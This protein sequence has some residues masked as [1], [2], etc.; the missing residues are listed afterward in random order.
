METGPRPLIERIVGALIP[1]PYREHVLGDLCQR[2]KSDSQYV[3]DACRVVPHVLW[4]QIRRT[5]SPTLLVAEFVLVY[6]AFASAQLPYH[7]ADGNHHH[8]ALLAAF[9]AGFFSKPSALYQLAVPAVLA[10]LTLVL[11]DAY[12]GA[13]RSSAE[14]SSDAMLAIATILAVEQVL[15]VAGSGLALPRVVIIGGSVAS[16]IALSAIRKVAHERTPRLQEH[17]TA[18]VQPPVRPQRDLHTWWWTTAVLGVVVFAFLFVHPVIRQFRPLLIAWLLLFAAIGI[19]QRRK[20]FWP[21]RTGVGSIG[22][23]RAYREALV[24]QRD[25]QRKWPFRR[26]R[27]LI[28]VHAG[29][30]LLLWQEVMS[31]GVVPRLNLALAVYILVVT[32]W[33]LCGWLLTN[34]AARAFDRQ[35]ALTEPGGMPRDEPP[36]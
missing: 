29:L 35:L 2:F 18:P 17:G 21:H 5:S 26:V 8:R 7:Y 33:L 22:G 28:V 1:P 31:S 20:I 10:L 3:R 34:R 11:R 15:S 25:A 23:D 6:L 30:A 36:R 19:Y 9:S 14:V 13:N 27:T 32:G 24:R 16:L 12:A 4:S